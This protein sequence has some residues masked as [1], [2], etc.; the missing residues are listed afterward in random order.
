VPGKPGPRRGRRET[1]RD[2]A[3]TKALSRNHKNAM[4]AAI[5]EIMPPTAHRETEASAIATAI[6]GAIVRA[7][8]EGPDVAVSSL[9]RLLEHFA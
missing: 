3:N 6:D 5:M 4:T 8:Y 1:L 2:Y 7:Q 9:A